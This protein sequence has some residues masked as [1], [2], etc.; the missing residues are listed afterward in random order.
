MNVATIT[1]NLVADPELRYTQSGKAVASATV[2][3]K[4]PKDQAGERPA[5][6]M[7]LSIWETLGE[8]AAECLKKGDRVQVSGRLKPREY[9]AKDGTT[10]RV[11]DLVAESIGPEIR[12]DLASIVK[13]DDS[14][15]AGGSTSRRPAPPSD[16]VPF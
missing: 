13:S 16:D 10:R 5:F 7:D 3:I 6:F 11:L 9:E 12:F 4:G 14:G 15:S 2:V 8:Q 1:G